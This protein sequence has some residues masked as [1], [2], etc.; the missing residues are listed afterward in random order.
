MRREAILR[1]SWDVT[2]AVKTIFQSRL[3]HVPAHQALC[4][5]E[6]PHVLN[7]QGIQS[8]FAEDHS[9][10]TMPHWGHVVAQLVE[11]LRYKL[12]GHGFDS[13]WCLWNFSIV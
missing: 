9:S 7:V 2:F 3:H 13:Q 5:Q 11:A 8:I 10:G 12:E 1:H 6:V 4:Q